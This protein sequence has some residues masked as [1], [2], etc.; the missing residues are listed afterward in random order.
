MHRVSV[1]HT[2]MHTHTR[3]CTHAR[4]HTHTH[5]VVTRFMS[6][7]QHTHLCFLHISTLNE[8]PFPMDAELKL[9]LVSVDCLLSHVR[10][11]SCFFSIH[12]FTW[13]GDA[14]ASSLRNNRF[15]QFCKNP[16]TRVMYKWV[17][18]ELAYQIALYFLKQELY[19]TLVTNVKTGISWQVCAI[20]KLN[21]STP[22]LLHLFSSTLT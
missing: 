17:F 15:S 19:I 8:T 18:T 2:R 20:L 14:I 13:N 7:A 21:P 10:S 16:L 11:R 5:T 12:L 6:R 9:L 3:A 22:A 1:I 4:M